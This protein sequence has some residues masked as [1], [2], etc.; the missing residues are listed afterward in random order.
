[1]LE[2]FFSK[3]GAYTAYEMFSYEHIKIL[4]IC[5]ICIVIGLMLSHK[6][7]K[8]QVH[9]TIRIYTL[10]LWTM[11]TGK[12]IF[13]LI[14]GSNPNSFIPLYFCSIPLYAGIMSSVGK[15]KIKKTGDVFL[16]VGGVVGGI[17]YIISPST[18]AG[19][20]PGFH[21]ITMQSFVHHALMVYLGILM[22]M[23]E[24]V[25]LKLKDWKYYTGII[26]V[27]SVIAYGINIVLD[28]NLMFITRTFQGTA[29]DVVY[30]LSPELF[31]VSMTVIQ[32]VLPYFVVY[33]VA[34]ICKNIK[35]SREELIKA[36]IV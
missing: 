13:N 36:D 35:Q 27:V 21:F 4:I 22:L 17:A 20:Y 9:K 16:A 33:G 1:M 23:K 11:E 8:K 24:Y 31:P 29:I 7:D 26:S 12:I 34:K 2:K 14:M 3:S 10:V 25:Q 19:M 5:T 32:G 30:K 18:T 6:M 15:G 28:T